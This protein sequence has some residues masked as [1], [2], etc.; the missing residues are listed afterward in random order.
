MT[1]F[2]VVNLAGTLFVLLVVTGVLWWIPPLVSLVVWVVA[3][4]LW[5]ALVAIWLVSKW[6]TKRSQ[7]EDRD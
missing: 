5:G 3:G 7:G 2:L 6:P 4:A 1:Q